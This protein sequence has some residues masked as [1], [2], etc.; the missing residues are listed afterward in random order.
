MPDWQPFRAPLVASLSIICLAGGCG[1]DRTSEARQVAAKTPAA[2]LRAS[3]GE[4]PPLPW[5]YDSLF[6]VGTLEGSP[7]SVFGRLAR[8]ALDS[9]GN[10]YVLD[11]RMNRFARIDPQGRLAYTF[12][13]GGHGPDEFI[14]LGGVAVDHQQNLLVVDRGNLRLTVYRASGAA[15]IRLKEISLPFDA[16]AI[17][18]LGDR[19]FLFGVHAGKLVH[20]LGAGGAIVQSFAAAP[21][22]DQ[23]LLQIARTWLTVACD[24]A[25]STIVF[26][27][28]YFP[29]MFAYSPDGQLRWETRLADFHALRIEEQNGI[30]TFRDPVEGMMHD[31]AAIHLEPGGELLLSMIGLALGRR[32]DGEIAMRGA[33]VLSLDTGRELRRHST[34][35]TLHAR[36][37]ATAY[38]LVNDP[39]PQLQ[40]F[41]ITPPA[42]SR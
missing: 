31:V 32:D 7:E 27:P 22:P 14:A 1:P 41:R 33:R 26:A 25:S 39:F 20:E 2:A 16:R 29:E 18:T 42:G 4:Y 30:A 28:D 15:P 3:P 21:Q 35:V 34:D 19:V 11:D 17:C 12:G 37:G 24:P 5:G 36:R 40:A 23:P 6:T 9:A 38:Q 8:I 13:R 10:A